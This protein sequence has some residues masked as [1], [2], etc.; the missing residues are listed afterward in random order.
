MQKTKKSSLPIIETIN[1]KS[2]M[3]KQG[4]SCHYFDPRQIPVNPKM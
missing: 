1:N 4:V 3:S 2:E